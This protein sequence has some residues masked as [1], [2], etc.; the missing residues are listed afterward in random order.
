MT[1]RISKYKSVFRKGYEANFIEELFGK[2]IPGDPNVYELED[3][4]GEPIIGK[5]YEEDFKEKE[6]GSSK[7]AWLCQ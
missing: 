4:D 3:L 6:N 5:F 7:M 2:L 1:V